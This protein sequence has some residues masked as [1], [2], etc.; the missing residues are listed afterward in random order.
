MATAKASTDVLHDRRA[1]LLDDIGP[2]SVAVLRA[3]PDM[4]RIRML[5]RFNPEHIADAF[6]QE[7]NF[8]YL[9]GIEVP[10]LYLVLNGARREA[11]V[12]LPELGGLTVDT[13]YGPASRREGVAETV[14]RQLA[15]E[16]RASGLDTIQAARD[17]VHYI[18]QTIEHDG[19]DTCWVLGPA[20]TDIFIPDSYTGTTPPGLRDL[21]YPEEDLAESIRDRFPYLQIRNLSRPL[22][23]QRAIKDEFELEQIRESA[24]VSALAYLEVMRFAQPGVYDRELS[25]VA[26]FTSRSLGGN[27]PAWLPI[28]ESGENILLRGAGQYIGNYYDWK[29]RKIRDGDLVFM[30][31]AMEVNYYYA[32]MA[33]TFPISGTFTGE[34]REAYDLYTLPFLR[35]KKEIRPGKTFRDLVQDYIAELKKE[36]TK[37]PVL[38]RELARFIE[39]LEPYNRM[40]HF[41]GHYVRDAGDYAEPL[42]PGQ[43]LAYE[44][45]AWVIPELNIMIQ[46]ED[47]GAIT[48]TGFEP[49]T[50]HIVPFDADAIEQIMQERSKIERV[51]QV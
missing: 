2:K 41:L 14:E 36:E 37:H 38:K 45:P 39:E 33:R 13:V 9:T 35:A 22:L 28:V 51:L 49:F 46:V 48:D 25:A 40:G 42:R 29:D 12:F 26:W 11:V 23:E 18:Y 34:Q 10:N 32:D 5:M 4:N 44:P 1:R 19:V 20:A 15:D 21:R 7:E 47:C 17:F 3:Q 30:D 16:I 50:E 8:F 24:R 6:K 43:V 27:R 31:W